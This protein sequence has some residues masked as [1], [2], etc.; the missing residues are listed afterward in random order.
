MGGHLGVS[1]ILDC[2]SILK[3]NTV[4]SSYAIQPLLPGLSAGL[5]GLLPYIQDYSRDAEGVLLGGV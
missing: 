1:H 4:T 3:I 5:W 2:V